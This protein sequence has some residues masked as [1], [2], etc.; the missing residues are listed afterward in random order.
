VRSE[1]PYTAISPPTEV[2]ANHNEA[3]NAALRR[4]CSAY[5]RRQNLYAKTRDGLQLNRPVPRPPG[6][7]MWVFG[8]VCVRWARTL[9]GSVFCT[10]HT[11]RLSA[12]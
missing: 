2:N 11:E 5:R 10:G 1:H 7:C 4:R 12:L 6:D 3:H 9:A 8:I